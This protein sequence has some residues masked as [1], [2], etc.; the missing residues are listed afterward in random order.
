[1]TLP[2]ANSIG[3]M[4]VNQ[5]GQFEK[6]EL[7]R[8]QVQNAL[9]KNKYAEPMAQEELKRK[10][11]SNTFNQ[12]MNP[13][14][15]EKA[16]MANKLFM[17]SR[18]SEIANRTANT[19]KMNFQMQNPLYGQPGAAGQLGAVELLKKNPGLMSD[20][21][22]INFLQRSMQSGLEGKES[23]NKLTQ[24]QASGYE[25]NSL[26]MGS[27]EY[28]L[29]QVAGMGID[30]DQGRKMLTSGKSLDEIAVENGYDPNNMPEPV[31]PLTKAG[32]TAFK[33][34]QAANEE[35]KALSSKISDASKDY[36]RKLF[37]QSP[38]LILEALQGK[39]EEGQAKALA[40]RALQ[41]ELAAIR[42]RMG[43]GNVGIEAI[44]EMTNTS[45]GHLNVIDGMISPA[46]Y[47]K[48]QKYVDKWLT[49]AVDAAN[50]KATQGFASRK[51]KNGSSSNSENNNDSSSN[52]DPLGIR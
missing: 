45:M 12:Q 21:N 6:N 48:S 51:G 52:N 31:Y 10:Q 44:R 1:M 17:P 13:L 16:E 2:R 5:L 36:S 11:M 43:G 26:P 38:K 30:P 4:I 27:K 3:S 28:L 7:M 20:L 18:E 25:F 15:L 24:K 41:P 9:L 40:A 8:Q 34:R 19:N 46:V 23:Q 47:E 42:L 22:A 39:N 14:A 37:G 50:K 32:Q 35:I 33:N 49:E 29:A